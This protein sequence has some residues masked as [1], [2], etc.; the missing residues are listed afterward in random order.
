MKRFYTTLVVIILSVCFLLTYTIDALCGE[1]ETFELSFVGPYADRHPTVRNG[2]NPWIK[3]LTERSNGRLRVRYFEPGKLCPQREVFDCTVAGSI[4][5]GS[6]FCGLSPGKFPLNELLELP[7]IV[8]SAEAGSLLVWDLYQQYP[9]WRAEFDSVKTLW[10]WT[11]ATFQINTTKKLVRTLDD[12]KGMK[13]VAWSPRVYEIVAKL[14]ARPVEMLPPDTILPLERG[15]VDGVMCPLAPIRSF[16]ISD[17]AKY[18]TIADISV[19]PFWAGVNWDLW[20]RLPS[21]LQDLLKETTGA[22]MT[23]VCGLTLDEGAREDSIWMKEQG[24]EFYVLPPAEKKRWANALRPI[25]EAWLKKMEKKGF[26]NIRQIYDTAIRL[27][28]RYAKTTGR[29]YQE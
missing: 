18:H 21:D 27:G 29:G 12:L 24:H 7:F 22:K 23:K 16:R 25:R 10:Q 15:M 6:S 28:E 13:I 3:M 11:S 17:A 4:D 2:L 1:Q 19:G 5:I 20:K 8:P 14:G 26:K 9:A